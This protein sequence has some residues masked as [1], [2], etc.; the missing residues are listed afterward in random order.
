MKHEH[1]VA[2]LTAQGVRRVLDGREGQTFIVKSF[3][4]VDNLCAFVIDYRYPDA[5]MVHGF[6]CWTLGRGDYELVGQS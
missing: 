6:Q 5:S 3:G 1:T 4:G 2:R